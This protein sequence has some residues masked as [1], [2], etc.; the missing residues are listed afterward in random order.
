M[1]SEKTWKDKFPQSKLLSTDVLLTTYTG[2][3]LPVLG[4]LQ[5]EVVYKG[6]KKTLPFQVVTGNGP[7]LWGRNWLTDIRLDWKAIRHVK[8][9]YEPL[10]DKYS[11]VFRNELGTLKGVKVRLVIRDNAP[12]IFRKPYPVPYAIRGAIEKDLE[13]LER[14]GVIKFSDWAAPIVAVPKPDGSVRICGDFKVTI[15]PVLQVDQYPVPK[16]DYLFA[17]LGG[18]QKFT[19]LDLSHAYQQVL[20]DD[21]SREYVTINTHKGLYQ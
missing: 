10:I 14:L 20:L 18:G 9:T 3:K 12:T 19:K 6:Q 11:N 2:E 1:I 8:Q 5:V 7:P 16:T 13:R 17:M 4:Q 15:N 21:E